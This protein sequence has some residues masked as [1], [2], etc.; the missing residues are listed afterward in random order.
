MVMLRK[1]DQIET[2]LPAEVDSSKPQELADLLLAKFCGW[3]PLVLD[4]QSTVLEHLGDHYPAK[5]L[6]QV[7]EA[8]WTAAWAIYWEGTRDAAG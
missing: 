5:A 6:D 4:E 1:K 3:E 2:R 8:E 7:T